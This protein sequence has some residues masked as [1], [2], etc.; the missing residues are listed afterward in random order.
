MTR[1]LLLSYFLLTGFV[2]LVLEISLGFSLTHNAEHD[3]LSGVGPDAMVLATLVLAGVGSVVLAAV[4]LVGWELARST[5]RPLRSL[6]GVARRLA[7]GDLSARAGVPKGPPE[8]RSLSD[9]FNQMASRLEELVTSQ[10]EF[11]SH[12]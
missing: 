8:L 12:A 10:S 7:A 6:E 4:L 5:T 9:A 2:L 3:M 1:R 11:A